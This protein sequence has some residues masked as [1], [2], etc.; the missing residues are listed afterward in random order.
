MDRVA[1]F[2]HPDCALHDPGSNHAESALRLTALLE[3]VASDPELAHSVEELTA[4]PATTADL[5]RAHA[6]AHLATLA[7][8][9]EAAARTGEPRWLDEDTVVG[10]DSYRAALAG[11]GCAIAAA[12][13]AAGGGRAFALSRPPGHHATRDRAMGFCLVNNVAVAARA[14]QAL[15]LARK[16]LVVDWDA[17]H[18]N[19]TQDIFYADPSVYLVSIHL[20]GEYPGTGHAS[21]RGRGAGRGLTRNVALP[22]GTA[23]AGYRRRF[24]QALSAALATFEP[25]LALVSAGFD[26]LAGDPEGGFLLEPGDLHALASDLLAALPSRRL[27][28][29]AVLEGGYAL[30]RI[31]AGLVEVLRALSGLPSGLSLPLGAGAP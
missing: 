7:E 14:A 9:A 1:L 28:V 27:G 25:D 6:P 19:G 8:A 4:P 11:A 15:G 26:L 2:S 21:Q 18:G 17:H 23:F 12:C 13:R 5:A 24:G 3:A 22:P 16:V 10:A 30:E 29:A 31:G 20:G